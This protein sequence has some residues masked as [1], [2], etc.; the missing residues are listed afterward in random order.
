MIVKDSGGNFEPCPEFTGQAVCVDRT[1]LKKITTSFNGKVK[2]LEVFKFAFEVNLPLADGKRACVWSRN[3]TPQLGEKSNL[4]KF[5]KQWLGRELTADELSNGFD[6]D[7]MLGKPAMLVVVH[8]HKDGKTYANI[9]C[10]TPDKTATPLAPSGTFVRKQDRPDN[11]AAPGEPSDSAAGGS[12]RPAEKAPAQPDW[13]STK[14][15]VG[16]CAGLELRDLSPDQIKALIEKWMPL[17]TKQPKLLADDKRLLAALQCW[18]EAQSQ[19]AVTPP[20]ADDDL[21]F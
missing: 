3:F 7:S 6:P 16:K 15:H 20:S 18:H 10:C 19:P 8:E 5:L 13:A 21:P 2:E 17:V 9:A 11:G 4:R 14:V 1:P 12:Y